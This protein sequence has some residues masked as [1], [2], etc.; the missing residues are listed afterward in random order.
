MSHRLELPALAG[1]D[2]LGFLAAVGLTRLLHL[3]QP[4]VYL[5]F[6][7]ETAAAVLTSRYKTVDDIVADLHGLIQAAD[8]EAA[9]IDVHPDLPFRAGTGRDPMRPQRAEYRQLASRAREIDPHFTDH[10]LPSIATDMATDRTGRAALTPFMAPRG[11]QNVRSYFEKPLTA[12]RSDPG[13]LRE[14][15]VQ[16]RRV[17]GFTGEYLDHRVEHSAADH[18]RGETGQERG[19]PGATWLATMALPL[20]RLTGD[21]SRRKAT[22]WHTVDRSTYMIW[23]LWTRP[24]A[25]AA[26]RALLDHPIF[27]PLDDQPTLTARA[28]EPLAVFSA[29]AARRIP[30]PK[31]E[32][33]LAP[34]GLR[35]V[36]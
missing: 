21:G 17:P 14:A 3:Q 12:V 33:L 11:K 4:D 25:P 16:W 27:R 36:N 30:H 20:F 32:G 19:V 2:Q 5:S 8:D 13:Y 28:W 35:L 9:I 7:P 18:P 24:L 15:L 34:A 23:P 6:S 31:F 10:W 26:I 22:C 29:S 1:R